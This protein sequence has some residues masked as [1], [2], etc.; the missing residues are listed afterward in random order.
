MSRRFS[1]KNCKSADCKSFIFVGV[2]KLLKPDFIRII[3]DRIKKIEEQIK[4]WKLLITKTK[5]RNFS[6][7]R[8]RFSCD[9]LWKKWQRLI[10]SN[11]WP[12][13]IQLD[14]APNIS[15]DNLLDSGVDTIH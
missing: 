11:H 1:A 5:R 10:Y 15:V 9:L 4:S 14:F 3:Y 12:N 8:W 7:G 6:K 13:N 2:R